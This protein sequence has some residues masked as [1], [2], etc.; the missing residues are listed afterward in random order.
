M[1]F[2]IEAAKT[3]IR[4]KSEIM[5]ETIRTNFKVIQ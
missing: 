5:P 1:S 3:I 4:F 2:K